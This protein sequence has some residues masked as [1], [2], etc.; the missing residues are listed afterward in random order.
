MSNNSSK[1]CERSIVT[2]RSTKQRA[3]ILKSLESMG[4]S[5]VTAEEIIDSLREKGTPVAKSTVYRH[6]A[7]MEESG[8]LK[9]YLLVDGS[10]A[11]YQFVGD[12]PQCREHYHLMCKECGSIVHFASRELEDL[13]SGM[14]ESSGFCIDGIRTVFYGVCKECLTKEDELSEK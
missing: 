3:L 2:S 14:R 11:C 1:G 12:T 10:S 4:R 8:E 5:H 13:F 6:L 7:Q 9:K